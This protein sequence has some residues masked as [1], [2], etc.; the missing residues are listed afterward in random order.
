MVLGFSATRATDQYLHQV[1]GNLISLMFFQQHILFDIQRW[2]RRGNARWAKRQ[3]SNV[4]RVR[5]D[6]IC[7]SVVFVHT[8]DLLSRR[9]KQLNISLL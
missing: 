5:I 6:R 1:V 8:N 7:T 3:S 4:V 2:F 9:F